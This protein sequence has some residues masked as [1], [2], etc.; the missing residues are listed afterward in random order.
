MPNSKTRK[1]QRNARASGPHPFQR[2]RTWWARIPAERP[3]AAQ[4]SLETSD[5]KRAQAICAMLRYL[6]DHQRWALLRDLSHR[7]VSLAALF[8]AFGRG[9]L[10]QFEAARLAAANNPDLEPYVAQWHAALE[11]G[12]NKS[13]G[14]YHAQLRT[15]MP[16]GEVFTREEFRRKRVREWLDGVS[17]KSRNR[18]R[19]AASSF[20]Q[21][22]LELEVLDVNPVRLVAAAKEST[23]RVRWL[24]ESEA[25]AVLEVLPE[26]HR[27]LHALLM[28][29][30]AD[31]GSALEVRMRDVDLEREEV[32][33]RGTKTY[34]RE[35]TRRLLHE[36]AS[37]PFWR[38][39]KARK[40]VP[41]ARLFD[42]IDE[43]STRPTFDA[44]TGT[45]AILRDALTAVKV[46]DY[47]TRDHRHTFAVHALKVGYTYAVVAHQLGHANTAL[48]HKVYGKYVPEAAD[49]TRRTETVMPQTAAS[50]G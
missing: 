37:G 35:R 11:K 10:A 4:R 40:A 19:A 39:V 46:E 30:G 12:G 49:Y 44:T 21:Y 15:L 50:A 22:L 48:V 34:N 38:Y 27:A 18:Y 6:A 24:T 31:V 3:P 29:S 36:W 16:V 2:G 23:P 9:E 41:S 14:K 20:A 43:T 26:P 33:V 47:T 42:L 28:A 7:T 25:R 13:A 17:A 45:L 5:K 8:E 1:P 32:L